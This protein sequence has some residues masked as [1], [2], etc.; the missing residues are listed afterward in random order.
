MNCF[1]DLRQMVEARKRLAELVAEHEIARRDFV[2]PCDLDF[3][4][5]P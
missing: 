1:H 4:Q 3:C 5:L 2:S